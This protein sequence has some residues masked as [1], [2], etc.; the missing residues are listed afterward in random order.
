MKYSNRFL[1][2]SKFATTIIVSHL[3]TSQ[4]QTQP[5]KTINT[6]HQTRIINHTHNQ[7]RR[8]RRKEPF[9]T[10][11]NLDY[12]VLSTVEH[13]LIGFLKPQI[14]DQDKAQRSPDLYR[15]EDAT[16]DWTKR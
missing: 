8:V 13:K 2:F 3:A 11:K 5:I 1:T 16:L 9:K 15:D 10:L 12:K 14:F 6:S 7:Q 4:P